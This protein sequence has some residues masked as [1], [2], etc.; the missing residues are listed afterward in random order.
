MSGN[1]TCP[2]AESS[3]T[4]EGRIYSIVFSVVYLVNIVFSVGLFMYYRRTSVFL[5]RRPL[6]FIL[7]TAT[8]A[9]IGWASITLRMALGNEAFPCWLTGLLFYSAPPLVKG[10][11]VLKDARYLTEVHAIRL[12]R[13]L[14]Q[15]RQTMMRQSNASGINLDAEG[16][17]LVG[18]DA[19]WD[20]FRAHLRIIFKMKRRP[21]DKLKNLRFT[22]SPAFVVF[23]V[24]CIF[25]PF[26][27][28]YIARIS[29]DAAWNQGC[30]GCDI[31]WT[32][33][34]I[35]LAIFV[36]G[37]TVGNFVHWGKVS[38]KD[39][40][41]ITRETQLC[42]RA[43]FTTLPGMILY[44]IDPGQVYANGYF[45]YM[46]LVQICPFLILYIQTVHQVY[47]ARASRHRLLTSQNI[48]REERFIDVQNDKELRQAFRNHLDSELSPEIYLFMD[49]VDKFR[50]NYE[51][52][53]DGGRFKHAETIVEMFIDRK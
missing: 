1:W 5:R 33:A 46:E 24:S 6:N 31:N 10:P 43:G 38:E 36:V 48:N 32:D 8:G 21:D 47:L 40:L 49:A 50:A 3:L 13:E 20:T 18:S 22:R 12:G 44:M 23:W 26:M 34:S 27:V 53:K 25:L 45:N 39:A 4:A 37:P 29:E 15:Q 28:A 14:A 51:K 19:S 41:K 7:I 2:A 42:W 17:D 16:L 52:Y 9:V 11:L 35:M 30:T